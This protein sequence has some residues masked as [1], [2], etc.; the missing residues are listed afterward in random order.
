[1][2]ALLVRWLVRPDRRARDAAG[3]LAAFVATYT[4]L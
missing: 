2:A 1:M 3:L 4:T